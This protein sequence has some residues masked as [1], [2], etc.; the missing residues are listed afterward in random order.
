MTTVVDTS[1]LLALLY[2]DDAHNQR[3]KRAL[4]AADEA[5]KITINPIV[6]A[7]LAADDTFED[8][9]GLEYFLDDTGI[10]VEPITRDTAARAGECFQTY[11]SR[12]GEKLQCSTCGRETTFECPDC[13]SSITARQ[14]VAADFLIGAHAETAGTLLT[15]DGGFFRDYFDVEMLQ[16]EE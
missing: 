6:Y 9:D 15:F 12:R 8:R 7:E 10:A 14:H 11:V 3:A 5:G 4:V 13:E 2:P 16:I 1:A